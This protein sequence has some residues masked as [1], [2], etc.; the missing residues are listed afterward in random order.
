MFTCM[1]PGGEHTNGAGEGETTPRPM[2]STAL[3]SCQPLRFHVETQVCQ[4][5]VG[6]AL[7]VCAQVLHTVLSPNVS[8]T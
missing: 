6:D 2:L 3:C 7:H 8:E 4:L 1:R 5:Q